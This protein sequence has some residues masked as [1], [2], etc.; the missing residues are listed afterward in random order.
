MYIVA[1]IGRGKR[2]PFS[3][4][5]SYLKDL[6]SNWKRTVV[7]CIFLVLRHNNQIRK[8]FHNVSHSM[9]IV[10]IY[11]QYHEYYNLFKLYSTEMQRG[12]LR[13]DFPI[14]PL[15]SSISPFLPV[16]FSWPLTSGPGDQCVPQD[17]TR[18]HLGA[19]VRTRPGLVPQHRA[20]QRE[21]GSLLVSERHR[22]QSWLPQPCEW[23]YCL[24]C[25]WVRRIWPYCRMMHRFKHQTMDDSHSNSC[26]GQKSPLYFKKMNT[27]HFR[28]IKYSR[29]LDQRTTLSWEALHCTLVLF[30]CAN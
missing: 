2:V 25:G 17:R 6:L 12:K 24:C 3:L 13:K 9:Y 22:A 7:S 10:S 20:D 30:I 18:D 21:D 11:I 19:H 1:G 5:L 28:E 15:F 27:R 16:W 4:C 26:C 29:L 14:H 8:T 23:C